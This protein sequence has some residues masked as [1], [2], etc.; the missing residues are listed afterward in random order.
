MRMAA[1]P[2]VFLPVVFSSE[3]PVRESNERGEQVGKALGFR[4]F[5][6]GSAKGT[7]G[8]FAA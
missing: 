7:G 5:A 6:E 4:T 1:G 3:A 2:V 8:R